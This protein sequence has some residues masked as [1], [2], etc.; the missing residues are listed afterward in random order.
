MKLSEHV[1]RQEFE[2]SDTATK[3]GISNAMNEAQL[4]SAKALC[5]NVF[6]PIRKHVGKP[7]RINSG[8]RSQALNKRIGASS[9]QHLKGEAMDLDLTSR[10]L[11]V[12]IL[13]NVE[14]DQAIYEFGDDKNAAWFHLSYRSG[15]NRKQALK[16]IKVSGGTQYIPFK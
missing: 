6:E 9:S 15:N 14:F 11:F 12:W 5:E 3:F 2:R 4:K 7:I 1:T 16:A 13:N 8:F 10:E